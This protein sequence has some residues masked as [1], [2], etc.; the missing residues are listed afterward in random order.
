M[1]T[2]RWLSQLALPTLHKYASRRLRRL[3][4]TAAA[5]TYSETLLLPKTA[6]PLWADPAQS[7]VPFREKTCERLYKWQVGFSLLFV[8]WEAP[9]YFGLE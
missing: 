3:A 5:K 9:I 1:R 2:S 8:A 7:E 6:F 4:S